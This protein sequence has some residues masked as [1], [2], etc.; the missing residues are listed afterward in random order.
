MI[1]AS[2]DEFALPFFLLCFGLYTHVLK[3]MSLDIFLD[4]RIT[5]SKN[6]DEW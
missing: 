3:K 6:Y 4:L 5:Y 1:H 2:A